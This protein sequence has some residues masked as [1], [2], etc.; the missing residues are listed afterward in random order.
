MLRR[1][2]VAFVVAAA[3]AGCGDAPAPNKAT[4]E[5]QVRQRM[6]E[7]NL[8]QITPGSGA[9]LCSYMVPDARE[10]WKDDDSRAATAMRDLLPPSVVDCE[11]HWDYFIGLFMHDPKVVELIRSAQITHVDVAGETA[12]ATLSFGGTFE[13]R[14]QDGRWLMNRHL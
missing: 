13:W 6:L 2:I 3:I 1:V 9:R 10:A 5:A 8:M 14:W 4:S 7:Y 12:A 11:S